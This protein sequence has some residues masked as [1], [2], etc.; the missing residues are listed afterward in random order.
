[1]DQI[2]GGPG[3]DILLGGAGDDIIYGDDRSSP[4][5]SNDLDPLTKQSILDLLGEPGNDYVDAGPGKDDV[6]D[7]LGGDDFLI[8]GDGDDRL[9][10]EDPFNSTISYFN[11]LDGGSGNDYLRSENQSPNGFDTLIGGEG[12]DTLDVGGG[13]NAVADGGT[14]NDAY[15]LFWP[16]AN[17]T[18]LTIRD[19]DTNPG[20]FDRIVLQIA[21]SQV[22]ISRDNSNLYLGFSG[23][24][25][26]IT[27]ENWFLGN[28]FKIEQIHFA[29][30]VIWDINTIESLIAPALGTPDDDILI[31]GPAN[32]TVT[33]GSGADQLS[34][35][36]GDDSYQFDIGDGFDQ[37]EDTAGNNRVVFG[38]GIVSQDISL[39]VDSSFC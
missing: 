4:V 18:R 8:G 30:G 17:R 25:D 14:G 31:G 3:S 1:M 27:V 22:A 9:Y 34:G 37:I 5:F 21:P 6:S 10:N 32:D 7:L 26:N 35:G 20:H 13:G 19:F 15:R 23:V 36:D 12:N 11:N 33:G 2:F 38:S 39:D 16:N 28:E 29:N 24:A